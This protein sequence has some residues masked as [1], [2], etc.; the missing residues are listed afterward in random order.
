MLT[1]SLCADSEIAAIVLPLS[2]TIWVVG[3]Q[4]RIS[5][6]VIGHPNGQTYEIDLMNGDPDNAQLVYV[7]TDSAVPSSEG[8]NTVTIDIPDSISVG[9]YGV[10]VGLV[11]GDKWKYSQIFYIADSEDARDTSSSSLSLEE[12]SYLIEQTLSEENGMDEESA[13]SSSETN[14]QPSSSAQ[15]K[16]K[17]NTAFGNHLSIPMLAATLVLAASIGTIIF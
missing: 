15:Y 3:G 10:R 5:Y 6:R 12:S 11:N 9:R 1:G 14:M 16:P 2:S 17:S 8:I 13:S 4:G 7:L